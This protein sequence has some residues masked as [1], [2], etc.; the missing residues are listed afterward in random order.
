MKQELK[1]KIV[2]EA[3]K[4]LYFRTVK[5]YIQAK[6]RATHSLNTAI[7]PSNFEIAL[8][9]DRF[10]DGM[11]NNRRILLKQMRED[12]LEI[13]DNLR[14]FR[15]KLIGS[16][17]R[18]IVRR[19]SDIDITLFSDD[20]KLVQD[21]VKSS[22]CNVKTEW[23][24]RTSNGI[25]TKFFHIYFNSSSGYLVESV[26][27][28]PERILEKRLCEIF[29]DTITGLT[30]TQLRKMLQTDPYKRYLPEKKK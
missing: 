18:G 7:F 24:S 14:Q 6:K 10:A 2:Q 11:E 22:Y 13:M 17:W 9:L 19:G 28:N 12:A 8:E 25:T 1:E 26:V 29:G 27:R 21:V 3:A 5:S 23:Q 4:L 16:V 15:P 30:R 20:H